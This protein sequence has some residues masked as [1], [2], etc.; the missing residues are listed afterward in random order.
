M[1]E[2]YDPLPK[3]SFSRRRV[4]LLFWVLACAAIPL[5][6]HLAYWKWDFDV[7]RDTVARLQ[8]GRDPYAEQTALQQIF[9]A[10]LAEHAGALLPYSYLYAPITLPL[11]RFAGTL[12]V[13]LAD[14][15][16][17]LAYAGG[18]LA[19]IWVAMQA[20]EDRE[21]AVFLYLAPLAVFF[22]GTLQADSI[23]SGNIAYVLYGAVLLAALPG[24]RRGEWRLFY[25]A[26]LIAS[27]FKGPLLTLLA[28]PLLS[29]RRQWLPAGLTAGIGVSLYGVQALLAPTLFRNY[30]EAVRLEFAYNHAFGCSPAGLLGGWL[31][32]QHRAYSPVCEIV[33]FL[34]AIPLFVWMLRL[35]RE[36]LDGGFSLRQWL[37]V[38]LAGVLLLNPRIHEYDMA[39]VTLPLALIAWRF[40]ARRHTERA[41]LTL[42][43]MA[44]TV[45]NL[46]AMY[47]W[48]I[49]KAINGAVLLGLFMA[50][51]W[52]LSRQAGAA[53]GPARE[54]A[55][56]GDQVPA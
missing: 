17:L 44:L 41:A 6:I 19:E 13:W 21:W 32:A 50:G 47:G 20:L 1:T 51:A 23:L 9:H 35:S 42:T 2:G 40:L 16:Y 52:T 45:L 3:R 25:A 18:A 56:L 53:D 43:A 31:Y 54:P 22:P 24:W 4:V 12:P 10:H 27:C 11:L 8:R 30:L 37:P 5:W 28:I 29:A 48:E 26:V 46:T 14:L 33:Y 36:W 15:L 38:M 39:M 34:Y 7:Y 55:G 49:R